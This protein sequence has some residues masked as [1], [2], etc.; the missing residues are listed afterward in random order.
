MIIIS[1]GLENDDGMIENN[2][3]TNQHHC[4]FVI[5]GII[6]IIINHKNPTSCEGIFFLRNPCSPMESLSFYCILAIR[7][8]VACRLLLLFLFLFGASFFKYFHGHQ[9]PRPLSYLWGTGC[10]IILRTIN[11][12][13]I[14][15]AHYYLCADDCSSAVLHRHFFNEQR[16][17]AESQFGQRGYFSHSNC[18]SWGWVS[19]SMHTLIGGSVPDTFIQTHV[20]C[21]IKH[22]ALKDLE[23]VL[24]GLF[25]NNA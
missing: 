8:P 12:G 15:P 19:I 25:S 2:Q 1:A 17:T 23:I 22:M 9:S 16:K 7:K 3:V 18:S 5:I 13:C 11:H 4:L 10:I 14:Q 20:Y 6:W 21:L 24:N